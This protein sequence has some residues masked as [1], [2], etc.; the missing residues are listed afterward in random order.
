M[1]ITVNVP[2]R[3]IR[4]DNQ[5]QNTRP[6]PLPRLAIPTIPP[7]TIALTLVSSSK[8]GNAEVG[9]GWQHTDRLNQSRCHRRGDEC[10]G[11]ESTNGDA[12]DEAATIREP[13]HQ[14]GHRNDVAKSEP[15]SADDAVAEIQPPQFV[16][17]E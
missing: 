13:F 17:R 4:S 12:G 2:R 11:A 16:G 8:I 6:T 15:Y 10:T 5:A 14:R 3:V 7:A 9:E 1:N